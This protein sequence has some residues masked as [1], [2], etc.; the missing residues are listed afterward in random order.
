MAQCRAEW[1][2][3]ATR[4]T[5][6][7]RLF[8]YLNFDVKLLFHLVKQSFI[9]ILPCCGLYYEVQVCSHFATREAALP[10]HAGAEPQTRELSNA[11]DP[12][13]TKSSL[14]LPKAVDA[15]RRE[16]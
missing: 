4:L 14:K 13:D 9:F 8:V 12:G 10:S 6:I 2:G 15:E 5:I 3:I 11:P 1:T 7:Q 16:Q